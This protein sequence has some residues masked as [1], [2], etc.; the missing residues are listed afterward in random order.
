MKFLFSMSFVKVILLFTI[1]TYQIS[2]LFPA[3]L[4]C[5]FLLVHLQLPSVLAVS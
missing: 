2:E 3:D 5:Y 4:M 1:V